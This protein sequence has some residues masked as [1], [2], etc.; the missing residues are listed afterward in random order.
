LTWF[1]MVVSLSLHSNSFLCLLQNDYEQYGLCIKVKFRDEGQLQE[2]TQNLQSGGERS[3]ATAVY[4]ISLQELTHVPFCC[5]DEIN[6]VMRSKH[7]K[8]L[9]IM[10][11]SCGERHNLICFLCTLVFCN[12]FYKTP[13]PP[14]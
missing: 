12:R 10:D 1:V 2:L 11:H 4:M 3:V 5:V 7:G 13:A 6:Q 8:C 14:K 9:S